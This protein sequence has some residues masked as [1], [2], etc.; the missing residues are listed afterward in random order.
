MTKARGHISKRNG[1]WCYRFSFRDSQGA[2][3]YKSAQGFAT[4][5]S[6]L[7]YMTQAIAEI[8]NGRGIN[9]AKITLADYL[10]GWFDEY[11]RANTGRKA[12][13]IAETRINI[14]AYIVP[15]FCSTAE[16]SLMLAKVK[17][18]T[19]TAYSHGSA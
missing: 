8:D 16:R 3:R 7:K 2:R 9:P 13:T 17:P 14:A 6:A 12:N 19:V 4:K 1:S 10:R 15:M 11:R 5:A 18:A